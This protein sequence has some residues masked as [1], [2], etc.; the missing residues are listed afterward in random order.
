MNRKNIYILLAV[1][2]INTSSYAQKNLSEEVNVVRQYKPILAE[3]IK[4]NSN[5]EVKI[6]E[7]GKEI[8]NYN[9]L[10]HRIDSTLKISAIQIERMKN[11]SI[12]KLYKTY[13]RVG[14]GNYRTSYL[15]AWANNLRS[16][17]WILGAHYRHQAQVGSIDNMAYS[18]NTIDAYAKRI[19]SKQSLGLSIL[20]DR[21]VNHFYGYDHSM[22]SFKAK[23]VRQNFNLFGFQTELKSNAQDFNSLSYK[24]NFDFYTVKDKFNASENRFG[25]SGMLKYKEYQGKIGLDVSSFEDSLTNKNNLFYFEPSIHLKQSDINIELGFSAYQEFGDN[26]LFHIYPKID[27]NYKISE[28]DAI[29]YAGVN[30]KIRKNSYRDFYQQ[31]P[32]LGTQIKI[33]NTNEKINL[34]AGIRGKIDLKNTYQASISYKSLSK[35]SYF[36]ANNDIVRSYKVIYDGASSSETNID[37]NYTHQSNEKLRI[38]VN[39]DYSIYNTDTVREA[40]NKPSSIIRLGSNYNIANKFLLEA[41]LYSYS[42]MKTQEVNGNIK[43]IKGGVDLNLGIDYRYS[44]IISVYLNLNNVLNYKR[45]QFNYYTGLGFQAMLGASFRF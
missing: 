30:G 43:T 8:P 37:L 27:A 2:L 39:F 17:E 20:Y 24:S 14:G 19:Y 32:F 1:A 18:D 31:N 33:L 42:K 11:E 3:A 16:K 13:I 21:D 6:E 4:I 36:V 29:V 41:Q 45:E 12:A 25:L 26:S 22:T 34:Y 40:W 7:T 9:F 38:Y 28:I 44:K 15:E 10:S 23:N 35:E 5:P